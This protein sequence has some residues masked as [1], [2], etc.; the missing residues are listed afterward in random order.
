M[1]DLFSKKNI[2]KFLNGECTEEEA[3]LI[4]QWLS[5]PTNKDSADTI[6]AEYWKKYAASNETDDSDFNAIFVAVE[7]RT[8]LAVNKNKK[9]P[10]IA[11]RRIAVAVTAA[12]C[13]FAVF[14]FVSKSSGVAETI[15]VKTAYGETKKIKLPDGS[16][17][18]LNSNSLLE[19]TAN[20]NSLTDRQIYLDGEAFFSIK[21]FLR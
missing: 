4:Q 19:Y 2:F 21:H 8:G 6:L 15:S 10:I 12:A 16:I 13:L 14:F 1:L 3:Q 5:H 7:Q 9:A 11:L 17:V 20:W 18:T